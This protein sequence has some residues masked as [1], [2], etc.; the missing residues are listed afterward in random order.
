MFFEDESKENIDT[1]GDV[2]DLM[3]K[4]DSIFWDL[5][6]KVDEVDSYTSDKEYEIAKDKVRGCNSKLYNLAQLLQ[7]EAV[8]CILGEEKKASTF[9]FKYV[10][11]TTSR[12]DYVSD[13]EDSNEEIDTLKVKGIV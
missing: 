1:D 4:D 5:D 10:R 12:H 2:V 9:R 6:K 11:S 8:E 3:V 7:K 13:Y